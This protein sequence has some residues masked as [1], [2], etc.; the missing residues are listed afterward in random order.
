MRW[1][2]RSRTPSTND[3]WQQ[4]GVLVKHRPPKASG[5]SNSRSESTTLHQSAHRRRPSKTQTAI[6]GAIMR[7][8]PIL[9]ALLATAAAAQE[10]DTAKDRHG[11]PLP[12]GAIAR[13]GTTRLRATARFF[14]LSADGKTLRTV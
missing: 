13:L 9:L 7:S 12:P 5:L 3:T 14:Q 4:A 10:R 8:F 11:D 1:Q 6:R 2:P